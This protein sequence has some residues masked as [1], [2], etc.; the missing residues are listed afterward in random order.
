MKNIFKCICRICAMMFITM[1]L[2]ISPIALMALEDGDILTNKIIVDTY[3]TKII[4]KYEDT[5]G[6]VDVST[7]FKIVVHNQF[8]TENISIIVK[9]KDYIKYNI[10]D[11]ITINITEWQNKIF[12]NKSLKYEIGENYIYE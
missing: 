7:D 6:R 8:G 2:V 9:E 11:I 1:L 4:D 3:S 12:K 10:G 5:H